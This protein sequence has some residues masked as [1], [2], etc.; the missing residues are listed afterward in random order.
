MEGCS[1]RTHGSY[2]EE[3]EMK[4]LWQY[5]DANPEFGYL[6]ALEL[7]HYLLN[8]LSNFLVDILHGGAEKGEFVEVCPKGVNKG[9]VA[10]HILWNLKKRSLVKRLILS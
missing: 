2:I 4:V 10:M 5:R 3:T 9:I 1:S 7:E 6:Q 8:M